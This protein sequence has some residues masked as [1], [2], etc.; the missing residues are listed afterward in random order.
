MAGSE[1]Q[2][3]RGDGLSVPNCGGPT[4][5]IS[6]SRPSCAPGRSTAMIC[7]CARQ[8]ISGPALSSAD[9]S[10][11]GCADHAM[12]ATST[13]WSLAAQPVEQCDAGTD[14]APRNA[15]PRPVGTASCRPRAPTTAKTKRRGS[16]ACFGRR[17]REAGRHHDGREDHASVCC[18]TGRAVPEY[19]SPMRIG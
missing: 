7:S 11:A 13:A 2:G 8:A 3:V 4:R 17:H 16:P 15:S 6:S 5:H 10:A 14:T 18:G 9:Q 12:R 19:R 1:R